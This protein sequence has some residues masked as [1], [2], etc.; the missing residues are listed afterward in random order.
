MTQCT[1]E[2][3]LEVLEQRLRSMWRHSL[4]SCDAEVAA[5][6]RTLR[7]RDS[8]L[9]ALRRQV[10]EL[11]AQIDSINRFEM[12]LDA[13][14]NLVVAATS[15][16]HSRFKNSLEEVT[17]CTVCME[18]PKTTMVCPC[19][20]VCLCSDCAGLVLEIIKLCPICRVEIS[21]TTTVYL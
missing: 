11:N 8:Q 17:N 1:N 16:L 19:K 3:Q 6:S 21:S 13:L 18:R 20:H 12:P 14:Q 9:S 4:V 2:N 5:L 10:V 7:T 15:V